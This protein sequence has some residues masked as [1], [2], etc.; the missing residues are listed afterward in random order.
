MLGG[1]GGSCAVVVVV[2]V[3]G[4]IGIGRWGL[5]GGLGGV[6][7]EEVLKAVRCMGARVRSHVVAMSEMESSFSFP[8]P[9][10]R[11]LEQR[12]AVSFVCARRGR[13]RWP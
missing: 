6:M 8:A 1:G 9:R 13:S 5:V 11:W 3:V 7:E 12:R 10:A 2:V 4:V